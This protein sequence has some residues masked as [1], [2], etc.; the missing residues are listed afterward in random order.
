MGDVCLD[1]VANGRNVEMNSVLGIE[2]NNNIIIIKKIIKI[3]IK[4]F[5]PQINLKFNKQ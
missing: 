5:F 3:I 2:C 1:S 4:Y